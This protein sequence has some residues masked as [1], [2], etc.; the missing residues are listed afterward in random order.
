MPLVI[1]PP[2]PLIVERVIRTWT[3]LD[4][5]REFFE[6]T[7]RTWPSLADEIEHRQAWALEPGQAIQSGGS[8][9]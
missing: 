4:R 2:G 5:Y 8:G 1:L 6:S 7:G 9:G 3:R